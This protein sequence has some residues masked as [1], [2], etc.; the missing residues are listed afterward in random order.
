MLGVTVQLSS[1][2]RQSKML[3][4]CHFSEVLNTVFQQ[5]IRKLDSVIMINRKGSYIL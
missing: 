2:F 5:L 3:Y 4:K 1:F